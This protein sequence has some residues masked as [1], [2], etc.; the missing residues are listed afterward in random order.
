MAIELSDGPIGPDGAVEILEALAANLQSSSSDEIFILEQV[1]EELIDEEIGSG[2]PSEAR[3]DFCRNFL[4][5]FGV[6]PRD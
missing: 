5:N 1:L 3:I 4:Q 2:H 6:Q